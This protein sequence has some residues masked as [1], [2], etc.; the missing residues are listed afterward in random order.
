MQRLVKNG[1]LLKD[2]AQIGEKSSNKYFRDFTLYFRCPAKILGSD[3]RKVLFPRQQLD[4]FGSKYFWELL[5]LFP[6]DSDGYRSAGKWS[7]C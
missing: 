2:D 4:S 6:F 1:F 7:V 3:Q 5:S